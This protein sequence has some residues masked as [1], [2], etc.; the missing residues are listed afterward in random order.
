MEVW[1]GDTK[2]MCVPGLGGGDKENSLAGGGSNL[3]DWE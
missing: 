1:A 2:R 3:D